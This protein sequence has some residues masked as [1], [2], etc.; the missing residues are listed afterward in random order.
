MTRAKKQGSFLENLFGIGKG[1]EQL[2]VQTVGQF[3][4]VVRC[5]QPG[6]LS[7]SE[8]EVEDLFDQIGAK[9]KVIYEHCCK[10]QFTLNLTTF[11]KQAEK[12][13]NEAEIKPQFR[14]LASMIDEKAGLRQLQIVHKLTS[15]CFEK[16]LKVK[17]NEKTT[18][19]VQLYMIEGFDFAKRDI[20][21]LS[22]PYL[23]IKSGRHAFNEREHYQ[24]DTSEPKFFKCFEFLAEFPGTKPVE[25]SAYDYDDFFGDELIGS[26]TVD[27][28]DRYFSYEWQAI[29]D[30]PVEFRKLYC[31][32]STVNQGVLKMWCEIHEKD[33]KAH[34]Q[35][36]IDITPPRVEEFEA[37]L[38]VWRTRDIEEMDFEGTTDIYV[39][40]FFD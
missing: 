10:D 36:P 27:L 29:E 23:V 24:L 40:A 6:S 35:E 37:R 16:Q 4:G 28:D 15:Y 11:V 34:S 21:S 38:V 22:D 20:D 9:V 7:E 18:C 30:K 33:S 3:K 31:E 26:T 2:Q 19:K 17:L 14:E 13:L 1:A 5:Y 32:S 39:R 8:K 12:S 25:I